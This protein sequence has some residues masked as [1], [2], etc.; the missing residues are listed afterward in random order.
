MSQKVQMYGADWCNFCRALKQ[1]LELRGIEYEYIDVE[2]GNNRKKMKDRTHGNETIP[3]L[4]V[5]DV[6][7]VNPSDLEVEELLR[8]V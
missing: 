8:D 4:F 5:D 2:N 7:K 1:K 6:Y 3:V